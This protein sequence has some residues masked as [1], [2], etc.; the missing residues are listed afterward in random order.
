[1]LRKNLVGGG[2]GVGVYV[3]GVSGRGHVGGG[4]GVVMGT[5]R[6]TRYMVSTR[7]GV[8]RP[9]MRGDWSEGDHGVCLTQQIRNI[10]TGDPR[11]A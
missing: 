6:R 1:M 5:S 3:C 8:S 4:R 2:T 7:G 9:S 11:V 10:C